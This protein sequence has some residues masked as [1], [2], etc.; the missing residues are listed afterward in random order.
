VKHISYSAMLE[1]VQS[2]AGWLHAQG[3]R[4]GDRVVIYMP[5][6]PDGIASML[7]CQ[8]LGA[9]HSVV[10]GGFASHELAIRINDCAPKVLICATP[11]IDGAK[12]INYK[13]FVDEAIHQS[14]ATIA[15][16]IKVLVLERKNIEHAAVPMVKGRDFSWDAAMNAKPFKECV[17]VESTEPS[18]ILYTSGTTGKPYVF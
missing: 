14:D 7:A 17:P 12:H 11:G 18:Y 16:N 3:V 10:F 2:I 8:R 5:M 6:I 15:A 9:I 13:K 4:K 1:S